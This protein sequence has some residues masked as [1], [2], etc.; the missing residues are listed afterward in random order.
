MLGLLMLIFAI[1]AEYYT[2]RL[3]KQGRE[4]K[5]RSMPGIEA[6]EE[7]IGRAVELG[8][9]VYWTPGWGG[10]TLAGASKG[11]Q[12][13]A[14]LAMLSYVASKTANLGAKLIAT[15]QI[16]DTVPIATEIVK[17]A[18]LAEGE[19]VPPGTV[20]WYST[21]QYAYVS[22][23]LNEI[24]I[25]KPGATMLFGSFGSESLQ[26][27]EAGNVIG[28]MQVCGTAG[29]QM[30]YL[31]AVVDYLLISEELFAAAAYVSKDEAS[32]ATILNQ[33]LIR[34]VILILLLL[35]FIMANLGITSFFNILKI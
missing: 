5:I 34:S 4:I 1:V 18:Y 12:Q 10:K 23:V 33:D 2:V 17:Q 35:S 11:S 8:R 29:S 28:A 19:T 13:I 16:A 6:I 20:R 26:I 3:A 27:A 31:I 24:K 22:G 14:A 9:P 15:C 7:A 25:E 32:L 30:P 21:E